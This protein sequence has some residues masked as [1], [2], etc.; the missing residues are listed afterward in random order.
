MVGIPYNMNEFSNKL[1]LITGASK[2]IGFALAQEL[3][4]INTKMI[5]HASSDEGINHLKNEFTSD[6]VVFW[7]ADF[8]KPESLE[9]G[10]NSL[11]SKVG[12]LDGYVN[13]VGIRARRPV[14]LF[15]VALIQQVMNANLVSYLE[16]IRLIT[17]RNRYNKGMSILS[18]TSISAHSGAP[19]VSIYAATKGAVESATRCMAKELYKKGIRINSLVSGQVNTEAYTSLMETKENQEDPVLSRQ[20]MGLLNPKQLAQA[21]LFLLSE[22]SSYLNGV[23]FPVDGGYLQ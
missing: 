16:I 12:P 19:G 11:L 21:C 18:I 10:L 6:Q 3:Y 20:Y 13:C 9:T 5:L 23:S 1:I 14:N 22:N 2:G 15:N 4:Q 7:Q 17:K 8:T